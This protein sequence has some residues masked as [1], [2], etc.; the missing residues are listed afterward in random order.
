MSRLSFKQDIMLYPFTDYI[1]AQQHLENR[2]R[3]GCSFVSAVTESYIK[4]DLACIEETRLWIEEGG[5]EP[6]K[7][8]FDWD[9]VR[10][11]A[12]LIWSS[13]KKYSISL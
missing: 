6:D 10:R 8:R 1:R 11:R 4:N 7:R 13:K 5:P 3:V 2:R 12:G 9:N